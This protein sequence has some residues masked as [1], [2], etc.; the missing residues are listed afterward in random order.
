MISKLKRD[1]L[2]FDF[3]TND[4][5]YA[6]QRKETIGYLDGKQ[7]RKLV[8]MCPFYSKWTNMLRRC[9][10][11]QYQSRYPTYKDCTVITEWSLFSTFKAWME[12]QDWECKQLDKD[13]L[14]PNNKIYS[15]ETCVF[16]DARANSFIIE[17]DATRGEWPIGVYFDKREGKFKAQCRSVITRKQEHLGY[18]TTPEEAHQAW[19]SFKLEQAYLLA[20][21]QSDKRIAKALIDKYKNYEIEG[22]INP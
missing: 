8:W 7:K 13:I 6:V 1:V 11:K 19:L 12:T 21:E 18:F 17:S 14:F 5:D 4:V 3:G 16:V 22:K 10:S 15:P 20:S 2:V 9:Y